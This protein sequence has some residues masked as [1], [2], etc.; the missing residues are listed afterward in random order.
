MLEYSPPPPTHAPHAPATGGAELRFSARWAARPRCSPPQQCRS[1]RDTPALRALSCKLQPEERREIFD[2][3]EKLHPSARSSGSHPRRGDGPQPGAS[4]KRRSTSGHCAPSAGAKAEP[5]MVSGHGEEV[6]HQS[7]EETNHF[8]GVTSNATAASAAQACVPPQETSLV[9]IYWWPDTH[10][11][12][13][14]PAGQDLGH[15]GAPGGTRTTENPESR[16]RATQTFNPHSFSSKIISMGAKSA[17][18]YKLCLL[19]RLSKQGLRAQ[20]LWSF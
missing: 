20:I 2:H 15:A 7:P 11:V 5:R 8:A 10:P 16:P 19:Y 6:H 13:H 17:F 14:S 9:F 3:W 1:R 18:K 4:S 12:C